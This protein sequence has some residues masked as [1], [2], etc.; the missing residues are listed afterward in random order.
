MILVIILDSLLLGGIRFVL[1][2]IATAVDQ[3]MN[4]EG[5]LREELLAAQMRYELGEISEEDFAAFEDDVLARLREIRER[6]REE[7]GGEGAMSFKPGAY[8]VDV[9]FTADRTYDE[10]EE[11]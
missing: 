2:K 10:E 5:R 6:E 8:G 1:D 3:E 7:T 9:S 11:P 4:D